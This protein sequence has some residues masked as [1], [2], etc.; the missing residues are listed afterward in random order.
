MLEFGAEKIYFKPMQ[1][2]MDLG[3]EVAH[4]PNPQLLKAFSKDFYFLF[5]LILKFFCY[6][7][8]R[9]VWNF[10]G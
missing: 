3:Q 10:S 9:G 8:P 1:G 2:D 4:A 5:L 6:G 7:R